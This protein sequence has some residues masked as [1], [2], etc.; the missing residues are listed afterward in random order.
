MPSPMLEKATQ[1]SVPET[2]LVTR[3]K[4]FLLKDLFKDLF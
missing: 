4:I 1:D 2:L 3:P